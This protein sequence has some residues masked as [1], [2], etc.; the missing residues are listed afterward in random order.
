MLL[1]AF[2]EA[3]AGN[4]VELLAVIASTSAVVVLHI[5]LLRMF[6]QTTPRRP[7][8]RPEMLRYELRAARRA[9]RQQAMKLPSV[10]RTED[11]N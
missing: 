4:V 1:H 6:N 5:L 11:G 3:S 8:S 2:D 10:E 9:R 7:V